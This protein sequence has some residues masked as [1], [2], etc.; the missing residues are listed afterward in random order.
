MKYFFSF[1]ILTISINVYSANNNSSIVYL[2][3]NNGIQCELLFK[4]KSKNS[5]FIEYIDAEGVKHKKNPKEIW[6]F[7]NSNSE[8]FQSFA[9]TI[10]GSKEHY[11]CHVITSGYAVLF[12]TYVEGELEKF[13][14][15]DNKTP[16]VIKNGVE[17]NSLTYLFKDCDQ[18]N[19]KQIAQ[20]KPSEI[21]GLAEL[22]IQYGNCMDSSVKNEAIVDFERNKVKIEPGIFI[23]INKPSLKNRINN[24]DPKTHVIPII[25][26]NC[27]IYFTDQFILTPAIFYSNLESLNERPYP[28]YPQ[29]TLHKD[30]YIRRLIG[31]LGIK[32]M[33]G[34]SRI[35][36]YIIVTPVFTLV[37]NMYMLTR[38]VDGEEIP[39]TAN[40]IDYYSLGASGGL[41]AKFLVS[42]VSLFSE[43]RY[44]Y[45]QINPK[46]GSMNGDEFIQNSLQLVIGVSF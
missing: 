40:S 15:I 16:V 19:Q 21:Q 17:V 3:K 45:E 44:T 43:I 4:S 38:I 7:R 26:I 36:P 32:Y 18:I 27:N 30:F 41:G 11:F 22:T 46:A 37:G 29:M 34:R 2:S 33:F 6:G 20:F 14:S 35:R 23:G 1:F 28:L 25:G 42:K 31:E 8:L 39:T 13:I 9:L 5:Q 12:T 10:N 24:N